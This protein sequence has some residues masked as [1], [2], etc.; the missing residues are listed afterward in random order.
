MQLNRPISVSQFR[1]HCIGKQSF[2]FIPGIL[3]TDLSQM[4]Y[5]DLLIQ[6]TIHCFTTLRCVATV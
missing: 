2:L 5:G 4:P 1:G 3:I 6:Y